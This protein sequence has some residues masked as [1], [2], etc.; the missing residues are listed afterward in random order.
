MVTLSFLM[1]DESR[2]DRSPL[3]LEAPASTA[4]AAVPQRCPGGSH[5]DTFLLSRRNNLGLSLALLLGCYAAILVPAY[6]HADRLAPMDDGPPAPPHLALLNLSADLL[7]GPCLPQWGR[8]RLRTLSCSGGLLGLAPVF[9]E[10]PQEE[11]EGGGGRRAPW[12]L[13]PPLGLRGSERQ[14]ARALAS[15]PRPGR[16]PWLQGGG[17]RRCVVVGSGG[18]LH[19]SH[20]GSS[21]DQYDV[22]IRLN[23]AP[24]GCFQRDAG[25]RTTIR[26]VYPEAAPA[27]PEEYRTTSVV[28]LV[29]FKSLDLD[30]LTSVITKRPLSFWSK[31]WFWRKVVEEIPLTAE[32]FRILNPEIIHQ[33]GRALHSYAPSGGTR[34]PTLGASA[35]VLA[36]QLCDQVSLAGFGYD[37]RHPGARLHYYEALRMDAMKGQVVHDIGSEKL[38]LRDLVSSGAVTDLT[39]AL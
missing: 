30:W 39:G 31:L 25:S 23:A 8:D 15:L 27:S 3:L 1:E 6:S 5:L 19:G 7:S 28:A 18:V 37:L 22:I 14:A 17:C 16:P 11:V 21:I 26:L 9:V 38:F 29:V 33:T 24:V 32:H 4:L 12:E 36:L 10:G 35:V 20:L 2:D 34:V 13:P